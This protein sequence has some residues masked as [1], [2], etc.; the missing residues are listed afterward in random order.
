MVGPLKD[1]SNRI[2]RT[3]THMHA[4]EDIWEIGRITVG[5]GMRVAKEATMRMIAMRGPATTAAME[6]VATM[7]AQW[8][9]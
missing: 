7:A 5:E 3:D 1:F 6:L 4:N 9:Q 2:S 8:G